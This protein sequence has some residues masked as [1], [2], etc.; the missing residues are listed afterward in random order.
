M[1]AN[2]NSNSWISD[3]WAYF[4]SKTLWINVGL[5]VLTLGVLLWLVFMWMDSYTRHG[6]QLLLPDYVD[7]PLE[8]SIADAEDRSFEIAVTDSVFIAGEEGGIITLQNPVG[9][10]KVKEGRTIYVTVTKYQAEKVKVSSLPRL[11]GEN[12]TNKAN[13]LQIGFNLGARVVG[14][15]FDPGPEGH[16]M[17]VI[18]EGDTIIDS[19]Y[20]DAG[21]EINKGSILDFILSTQEGGYFPLPDLKCKRLVEAQF[22][23]DALRISLGEVTVM[24][25][26]ENVDQAYIISQDPPYS[27]NAKIKIGDSVHVVVS[28]LIPEDCISEN[29]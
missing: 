4:K 20:R 18:H 13:E 1:A 27:E 2:Q 22:Q 6:Q 11:Y 24:G 15:Q 29:E 3:L 16:I 17:A 9:G 8:L 14:E 19:D 21:H 25:A 23:L 10:S 5:M 28:P 7:K 12:F 26:T